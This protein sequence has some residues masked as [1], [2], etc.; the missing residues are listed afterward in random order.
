MASWGAAEWWPAAVGT[1]WIVAL[2]AA[3]FTAGALFPSRFAANSDRP[4]RPGARFR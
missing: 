3:G 4:R 2:S 1:A